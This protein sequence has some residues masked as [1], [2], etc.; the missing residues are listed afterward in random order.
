MN[1]ENTNIEEKGIWSLT[2]NGN[3]VKVVNTQGAAKLLVN[4]KIQD[5][6]FGMT[7]ARLTGKVDGKDIKV[8]LGSA[9]L[10]VHCYIFIDN[11]LVLED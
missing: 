1:I 10:K 6:G 9:F 5:V 7:E 3:S 11:E 2:V 8:V 4:D